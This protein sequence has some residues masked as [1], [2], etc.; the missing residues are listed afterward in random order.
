MLKYQKLLIASSNP[1]KVKEI[2]KFLKGLPLKIVTLKDLGI[3]NSIEETGKT[4]KENA[5]LKARYFAKLSGILTLADDGGLEI[6]YLSGAPGV[7]SR[8]WLGYIM[9]DE[10]LINEVIKRLKGVPRRKR[11]C[12][13]KVVLA[14]ATPSGKVFT[15]EGV[16]NG[17]IAE[18]PSKKRI[19]GY[20]YRSLFY[21]PQFK[22]FYIDLNKKE[23][24]KVNQRKAALEKL[25]PILKSLLKS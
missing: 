3:K 5:I 1:A 13:L 2:K 12:A 25:K 8:R 24:D 17:I 15:S 14:L 22:K 21:L 4:F 10:E 11:K 7:K 20:P 18:T 9:T 16:I 19:A 23:H 6:K